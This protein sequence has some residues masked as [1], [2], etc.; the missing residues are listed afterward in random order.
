MSLFFPGPE[1][2]LPSKL[3]IGPS[4]VC[5]TVEETGGLF[6]QL[7]RLNSSCRPNLSRPLY[8]PKTRSFS[9]YALQDIPVGEELT[10]P[11]LGVSRNS[12]QP[13]TNGRSPAPQRRD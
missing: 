7:S 8:D 6:L 3:T 11:Y 1:L 4:R 9:L 2:N 5:S 12:A 10:W 13:P